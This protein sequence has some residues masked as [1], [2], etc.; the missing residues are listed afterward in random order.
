ML[1]WEM[2]KRRLSS[3]KANATLNGI[4]SSLYFQYLKQ[5]WL[6]SILLLKVSVSY[7]V[8]LNMDV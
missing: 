2:L 6:K 5:I 3:L 1:S 8:L 4:Y 7:D